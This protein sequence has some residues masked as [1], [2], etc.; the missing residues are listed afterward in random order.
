MPFIADLR[1]KTRLHY[2]LEKQDVKTAGL[3][4]N[5]L[6]NASLDHHAREIANLIPDLI[7]LK[8]PYLTN[9]LDKRIV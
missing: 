7:R 6:A 2:C 9:Y 5:Y 3:L 1:G 8:V 4:I